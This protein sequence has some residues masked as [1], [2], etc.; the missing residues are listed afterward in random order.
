MIGLWGTL[1]WTGLHGAEA[2]V[3]REVP[4]A[5][6]A[7][8]SAWGLALPGLWR[9]ARRLALMLARLHSRLRHV[10]SCAGQGCHC[11][12]LLD[13]GGHLD[14]MGT[15]PHSTRAAACIVPAKQIAELLAPVTT[16]ITT[17][18]TTITT[19]ASHQRDTV[20]PPRPAARFP[21]FSN[22]QPKDPSRQ[23]AKQQHDVKTLRRQLGGLPLNTDLAGEDMHLKYLQKLLP[24]AA[25]AARSLGSSKSSISY[26]SSMAEKIKA[27]RAPASMNPLPQLLFSRVV[28]SRG[29]D[30]AVSQANGSE[31]A[32][33]AQ[34]LSSLMS[35]Y[36]S[37]S[38]A[39]CCRRTQSGATLML[40]ELQVQ[41]LD[42]QQEAA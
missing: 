2:L 37:V 25:E 6:L 8:S 13:F 9:A 33:R 12:L 19:T 34:A 7:L 21:P 28:P 16:T 18:T 22:W 23:Q 27:G 36:S 42:V 40:P 14:A 35:Y 5:R 20:P 38:K 41:L 30:A 10:S 4:R 1:A 26:L 32:G 15:C 3:G 29:E 11:L 31:V 24:A 39:D 17:T